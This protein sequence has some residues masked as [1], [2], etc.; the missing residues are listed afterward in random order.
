MVSLKSQVTETAEH[1]PLIPR[2]RG[3]GRGSKPES[4]PGWAELAL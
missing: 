1:I 2:V 4:V 3:R